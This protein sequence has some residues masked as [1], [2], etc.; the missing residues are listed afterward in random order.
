MQYTYLELKNRVSKFLG[1]Y[2]SSGPSGTDLTDAEDMVKSGYLTF[3]TAYDWTFR[4]KYASLATASDIYI[5]ELPQDFGGIR[6]PFKF[7]SQSGYPA[8]Q[9]VSE[10]DILEM[11][12][13][14]ETT[15][16]PQYFAVRA[17]HHNPET[18]QRYEVMFW[19]TPDAE[20]VL[21]YSHYTMPP[22][23]SGDDDVPMGGAENSECIM[24]Y[25][26]AA[27]EVE[28]D[29]VAGVQSERANIMLS[30]SIKMDNLREPRSFSPS[31][32][33]TPFEVARGSYR[34]QDVTGFTDT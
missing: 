13:G 20:H 15:S 33:L 14:G 5:Y 7:T 19:P 11:R 25:C 34:I 28:Q 30:R 12:E 10:G 4:R 31:R 21:Y 24:C 29:E 1:T 26:L 3:L 2:G 6:T 18:G 32:Q 16:Y 22:M 8:L 23:M 9:E 27:A 17:G